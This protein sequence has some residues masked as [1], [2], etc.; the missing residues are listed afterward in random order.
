MVAKRTQNNHMK[1][2]QDDDSDYE[3]SATERSTS[4]IHLEV[5]DRVDQNKE[6]KEEEKGTSVNFSQHQSSMS[7]MFYSNQKTLKN[8]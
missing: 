7:K 2:N 5:F 8:N 1:K 4:Q 6:E 3:D